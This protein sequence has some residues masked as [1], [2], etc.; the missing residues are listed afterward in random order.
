MAAVALI[1]FTR[2]RTHGFSH[3]FKKNMSSASQSKRP[4][5]D[6]SGAGQ[7][8]QTEQP[9][10]E[11]LLLK[12]P[13]LLKRLGKKYCDESEIIPLL[14]AHGLIQRVRTIEVVVQPLGGDSFKVRLSA[15]KPTVGEAKAE[16]ARAHGTKEAL[17]DLF[18]VAARAD[19][20]A[21]RE[22]D[23]EPEPL[24][25]DGLE[26]AD[27]AV[28]ALAVKPEDPVEWTNLHST[29]N[30][31]GNTLEKLVMGKK[32][33]DTGFACAI[34]K[35]VIARSLHVQGVSFQVGANGEEAS[36]GLSS[37]DLEK[38]KPFTF[39][40][41]VYNKASAPFEVD[42][43]DRIGKLEIRVW[44][45]GVT[46][47]SVRDRFEYKAGSELSIRVDGDRVGYYYN[48]LLIYT[49]KQVPS[50]PLAVQASLHA[51]G[52]KVINACLL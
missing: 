25:D 35:Q 52:D 43:D 6:Q 37:T 51:V 16:I 15:A 45:N 24:D 31:D 26:L 3:A 2:T 5:A 22:D 38:D 4:R 47:E 48:E 29:M 44:E 7:V 33:S 8:P 32:M 9:G 50:F 20:G 46:V 10:R 28:V 41:L 12:C 39:E 36:I 30:F 23:A 13:E 1:S 19:G 21:V 11:Q 14:I 18:R 49:S 40:L 42:V 17:Q 34:S 27:G